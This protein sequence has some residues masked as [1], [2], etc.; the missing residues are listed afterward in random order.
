M[1]AYECFCAMRLLLCGDIE[2]NPG[3]TVEELLLKVLEG[4]NELRNEICGLKGMFVDIKQRFDGIEKHITELKT[5]SSKLDVLDNLVS[6]YQKSVSF[7]THK[8]TD[9]E[10][11]SRRSNLVVFGISESPKETEA[12]LKQKVIDATF[13]DKL[14]VTCK[15]VG[16]IHRIGKPGT[17]RPV[18]LFFQDFN[19]KSDVLKNAKKL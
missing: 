2:S 1:I 16:R 15:S 19:E 9:F 10:D 7:Q 14:G 4:Q 8:L 3:P 6:T 18:I 17:K 12:E 5:K 11:R 13:K